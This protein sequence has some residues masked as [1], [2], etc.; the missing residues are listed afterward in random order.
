[1]I[2]LALYNS[3][4]INYLIP[5]FSHK[6]TWWAVNSHLLPVVESVWVVRVVLRLIL[7]RS[8]SVTLGEVKVGVDTVDIQNQL[9]RV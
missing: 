4:Q 1:M 8:C 3:N 6:L 2:I 5:L 9:A 7:H